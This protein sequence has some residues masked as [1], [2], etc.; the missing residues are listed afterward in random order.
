MLEKGCVLKLIIEDDEGRKTT[1]PFVRDEITIGRQEGNTIRLTERNVSR[2]HARLLRNNGHILI[3]DLGSYNGIR[4]NGD[5]I[6][7]QV[8][9]AD[10]DLIQIGD[11][12]LAIQKEDEKAAAP[13]LPLP[14]PPAARISGQHR[15]HDPGAT[16]PALPVVETPTASDDD[17]QEAAP[18]DVRPALGS[19]DEEALRR[20]STAV[21]R[22]DQVQTKRR[23]L[24]TI[25]LA[26]APRLVVLNTDYAGKEFTLTRTE[27]K[28]GRTDDNDVGLDHRSLSRTHCKVVR[29]DDGEWKVIDMQSANGVMV[30]GEQY[31]QV[32]LN[33]GDV[34]ELGHVKFKFLMPGDTFSLPASTSDAAD[35][36]EAEQGSSKAP[37]IAVVATLLV[38]VL[39]GG[40]YL[41]WKG[42]GD[43]SPTTKPAK[44]PKDPVARVEP[45]KVLEPDKAAVPDK[46]ELDAK[47]LE[48][49]LLEARQAIGEL[50]FARAEAALKACKVG[51]SL[52]PEANQLL[53]QLDGERG[54]RS[55][56]E[57]AQEA[58]GAG[59]E[60]TAKAQLDAASGTKLLRAKY[61]ELER[62][63]AELVKSKIAKV[64]PKPPQP[65]PQPQPPPQPQPTK[66]G[67]LKPEAQKLLDQGR[68]LIKQKQYTAAI[69]R[70]E[71]CLKLDPRAYNCHKQ[72]GSAYA[73]R[74]TEDSNA[75]DVDKGRANYQRY[76]DLAPPD[77][78]D[79]PK[80]QH[81]LDQAK[82]K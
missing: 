56:L 61:E 57:K 82:Q 24:A 6:K 63:R 27:N 29:E 35:T 75:A 22:I 81:I 46:P 58:L 15:A 21:I 34:L 59:D 79:V 40:G 39:G 66:A 28:I 72:L 77:D 30:N 45:D 65:Q 3:E 53:T 62:Q 33:G 36:G 80:V 5:R 74:G 55:A 78:P 31:A 54:F 18:D 48:L 42:S 25:D 69:N 38:V 41:M 2:R 50:D 9:I 16:M 70:L 52:H 68:D 26:R 49:K 44:P 43:P 10:G 47:Q 67:A 64:E 51:D 37:I 12:D 1:V 11:Y 76:V 32:A 60:K 14:P 20:Q 19:T 23:E 7:G 8:T 4:V 17:V 71:Q 73:R 13:T